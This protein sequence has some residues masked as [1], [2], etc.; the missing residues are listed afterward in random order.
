MQKRSSTSPYLR[1]S[2]RQTAVADSRPVFQ[3]LE[4]RKLLTVLWANPDTDNPWE[5]QMF[6]GW[7]A[8][9]Q[10]LLP[11]D[12]L[13]AGLVEDRSRIV[14]IYVEDASGADVTVEIRDLDGNFLFPWLGQQDDGDDYDPE[15]EVSI[16]TGD[17]LNED[18]GYWGTD[19]D[20]TEGVFGLDAGYTPG[21]RWHAG[22]DEILGTAD[23]GLILDN[24]FHP[25]RELDPGED[26]E[27]GTEDDGEF[28]LGADF[29]RV[30]PET[31]WWHW[32]DDGEYETPDDTR[33]TILGLDPGLW[34][35]DRLLGTADDPDNLYSLDF[36]TLFTSDGAVDGGGPNGL[37]EHMYHHLVDRVAPDGR[38]GPALANDGIADFNN[39][40]GQIIVSGATRFTRIT[41]MTVDPDDLPE[42]IPAIGPNGISFGAFLNQI[43]ILD[44]F[45]EP[46]ET[47]VAVDVDG[48]S[49]VLPPGFG[50]IVVGNPTP[51]D[52]TVDDPGN[53]PL[54]FQPIGWLNYKFESD[55]NFDYR[56]AEGLIFSDS[57]IAGNANFGRLFID[58]A[59][60]GTSRA[61]G[62]FEYLHVGY[63]G[64]A[65]IV[66]GDLDVV[67]VAG[68]AGFIDFDDELTTADGDT[69]GF[70]SVGRSFGQFVVGQRAAIE[71][72]VEGDYVN[73][74]DKPFLRQDGVVNELEVSGPINDFD[75]L[76]ATHTVFATADLGYWLAGEDDE[77]EYISN[78]TIGRAQFI[79]RSTGRTIVQG[80]LGGGADFGPQSDDDTIDWYV[81]AVDGQTALR[82]ELKLRGTDIDFT[83]YLSVRDEKG[84]ILASR[85]ID[86]TTGEV[87]YV[88]EYAGAVYI[89]VEAPGGLGTPTQY[90]LIVEGIEGTS[91]GEFLVLGSMEFSPSP[92]AS[93]T[94]EFGDIGSIRV[95]QDAADEDE[96]T[97]ILNIA[98]T[99]AG[100]IWNVTSG[101]L[102]GGTIDDG[103]VTFG[104][105]T[106]SAGAHIGSILAGFGTSVDDDEGVFTGGSIARVEISAAGSIG[107]VIALAGGGNTEDYGDFGGVGL[108]GTDNITRSAIT[109]GDG[110]GVM[111]AEN[112]IFA[113]GVFSDTGLHVRAGTNGL[114]GQIDLLEAGAGMVA[115]A[116]GEFE[117]EGNRDLSRAVTVDGITG[118]AFNLNAGTQSASNVRFVRAPFV[119]SNGQ[120]GATLELSADGVNSIE[121]VDDSGATYTVTI[122]GATSTATLVTQ[123]VSGSRGVALVR[124]TATLSDGGDLIITNNSGLVEIGDLIVTG[125]VGG[126]GNNII[127]SGSGRTD[128]Y[129]LRAIGFFDEI[130]NSTSGDM[131][132]IDVDR[133]S[134]V[135]VKGNLGRTTV[136]RYAP[137]LI[138]P[139]LGVLT[140]APGD[141]NLAGS[142]LRVDPTAVVVNDDVELIGG[143]YDGF[144]NGLSVREV[145]AAF[146]L[147]SVRVDGALGDLIAHT[148]VEEIRVNAD[149]FTPEGEFHGVVGTVYAGGNLEFIDVGDGMERIQPGPNLN[150]GITSLSVIE[151]IVVSGEGRT[152][153]GFIA[154]LNTAGPDVR[155]GDDFGIELIDASKGATIQSAYITTEFLDEYWQSPENGESGDAQADIDRILVKDGNFIDNLVVFDFLNQIDIKNGYWDTNSLSGNS[156]VN[157]IRADLI[158]STAELTDLVYPI[159]PANIIILS[160][161]LNKIETKGA[162]GDIRDLIIDIQGNLGQMKGFN[163]EG[164]TLEVDEFIEKIQAKGRFARSTINAGVLSKMDVDGDIARTTVTVA[165]PIDQFR[166]KKGAI[167]R[168]D[169]T[170]DG[171]DGALKKLEASDEITGR[172]AVSGPIDRIMSKSS[173][174]VAEIVTFS[175]DGDIKEIRAGRDLLMTLDADGNVDKL[176]AGRNIGDGGRIDIHGDLK[177]VDVKKGIFDANLNVDGS[178]TSKFQAF[179][180]A[181]GSSISALSTIKQIQVMDRDTQAAIDITA[182]SGG[183]EKIDLRGGFADGHTISAFDGGIKMA[184]IM[185]DLDGNV[186]SDEEIT[187]L[188]V[189]SN[190]AQ[191]GDITGSVIGQTIIKQ[192][193]ASGGAIDA[194]I[195][196]LHELSSVNI[197]GSVTD[198]VIGAGALINTVK[199]SGSATDSFFLAGLESLGSDG[200]LGGAGLAADTWSFGTLGLVDI[201]GGITDV[202]FAAGVRADAAGTYATPDGDTDLVPGL[203]VIENVR[204]NG[205]ASGANMVIADTAIASVNINDPDATVTQTILDP[206]PWTLDGTV[207]TS[208]TLPGDFTEADGDIIR[209]VMTG[210]GTGAFTQN[211]SGNITGM[212]FVDTTSSTNV[213]I[214]VVGGS[215]NGRVDLANASIEAFDDASFNRFNIQGN[216][217][218]SDAVDFDGNVS[219]F[220]AL[221]VNTTGTIAI[222]GVLGSMTVSQ[223]LDGDFRFGQV[224][225]F[226][227]SGGDFGGATFRSEH[228]GS[229]AASGSMYNSSVYGRDFINTFS[230]GGDLGRKVGTDAQE[231]YVS[232]AGTLGNLSA[233]NAAFAV[234]SAGDVLDRVTFNGNV[235]DTDLLAGLSLGTD[236]AYGGGGTSADSLTDGVVNNVTIRGNFTRSNIAAGVQRG[237]G[238]YYGDSDDVGSLGVSTIANVSISGTASGSSF[239]SETFAFIASGT[240]QQVRAGNTEF[241]SESGN[242]KRDELDVSP[243]PVELVDISV[244]LDV[245]T[246]FIDMF[247]SQELDE[248]SVLG[249]DPDNPFV[250]SAF[251]IESAT[252]GV[253]PDPVTDYTIE[254]DKALKRVRLR[255]DPDFTNVHPDVYTVTIDGAILRSV[256]GTGLDGDGDGVGGDVLSRNFLLGDA[257]DRIEDGTWD[258][259]EG[260]EVDF[261]SATDGSLLLNGI[262]EE[263]SI[264]ERIGDHPDHDPLYF[265]GKMD[266]DLFTFEFEAGQIIQIAFEEVVG[267]GFIGQ[268]SLK[269]DT[270]LFGWQTIASEGALASGFLIESTGEY[271]LQVTG[272]FGAT[273]DL[274]NGNPFGGPIDISVSDDY[275]DPDGNP[276]PPDS[277]ANDIGQYRINVLVFDDGDT[278]FDRGQETDLISNQPVTFSDSIGLPGFNGAPSEAFLDADVFDISRLRIGPGPDGE[279]FTEDDVI[280][281]LLSAGTT[282]TVTVSLE[283]FGSDLGVYAE[284]GVFNTSDT[285][286]IADALMIAAPG[287]V[288]GTEKNVTFT[289]QIP[290]AGEYAVYIQGSF[291]TNYDLTINVNHFTQGTYEQKA[292]QNILLETAGGLGEW[293]GRFGAEFSEFSLDDLGFQDLENEIL[294]LLIQ[295]IQDDFEAIGITVN[296]A[297]TPAAF[298]NEEF[299]TVFVAGD[300]DLEGELIFPQGNYDFIDPLNQEDQ[301]SAVVYVPRFAGAFVP[302]Q[303]DVLAEALGHAVVHELLH[304]FGLRNTISDPMAP[305]MSDEIF[306]AGSYGVDGFEFSFQDR[307]DALFETLY[308]GVWLMGQQNEVNLLQLMF[309]SV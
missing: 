36:G 84:R 205:V 241:G 111:R 121:L 215:G 191:A 301:Q 176:R 109:A 280:T 242:L 58:G 245:D 45:V 228:L 110:I 104:L 309:E 135:I 112:R 263:I 17:P 21:Y 220:T 134:E 37:G 252:G 80:T 120:E 48:E 94:T 298:G 299:T 95:G 185:G 282:V 257:G 247:F 262:N 136:N 186:F 102:I 154:A 114:G 131:V 41:M 277:I 88:P 259:G 218:G 270:G 221:T 140:A 182:H 227:V 192:L 157:L 12:T 14:L 203:S 90:D 294:T 275:V 60:F 305:S 87:L 133:V 207:F 19:D 211:G 68:D 255:V 179:Q 284:V 260:V 219:T 122:T 141:D 271:V 222:D 158:M 243:V 76:E 272:N 139:R 166:S 239:F 97:S 155:T 73:I 279:F 169:M 224:G 64:G 30:I 194:V 89:V 108:D 20:E 164:L 235:S 81:V 9:P 6:M 248:S 217:D 57:D 103:T 34:S 29:E 113:T 100:S 32:G 107:R 225:S 8:M 91:F 2:R 15:I 74:V 297:L 65:V 7:V 147:E 72:F 115:N 152:L 273:A 307:A 188:D 101:N 187:K 153:S 159:T 132:A 267:S 105:V 149:G 156:D 189:K 209:I 40:I 24:F 161:N 55:S 256:S 293:L 123:P 130:R 226:T 93:I 98:I 253:D 234:V 174:V 238:G 196:A 178:I 206:T 85:G 31:G 199:V 160:G 237:V 129:L 173:D 274:L 18:D 180:V 244:Q 51:Y 83:E 213:D 3:P 296:V 246:F 302:G 300:Y 210:P 79:G 214:T 62:A 96:A 150:A 146:T 69:G 143:P 142:A 193:K 236:G 127:L 99:S 35:D 126:R 38:L 276:I 168:L 278:G 195:L 264:V 16:A 177:Q 198:A 128:V 44:P 70:I 183:I 117:E 10:W 33:A 308:G 265:P 50:H 240:V 59:L 25:V 250:G 201:S 39:G 288:D 23:D 172:I 249:N 212:Q 116:E 232:T 283:E 290:E 295:E 56:P 106:L 233:V 119:Y 216:I 292:E 269:V 268:L 43:T 137:K 306:S 167:T 171:P 144:L 75:D 26:D 52:W 254:Y 124:V 197:G 86:G 304:T 303:S 5:T 181:D 42:V 148:T 251:T 61:P 204:V 190:G 266:T 151:R 78:D 82:V 230:L 49:L 175:G 231:A 92:Q 1:R 229:F 47:G 11:D 165:G 286:G 66:D 125:T 281:S 71:T 261:L 202:V 77:L 118:G 4:P 53:N 67:V 28:D 13:D 291:R 289:F 145:G 170:I 184:K 22:F 163:M 138:G 258:A 27:L 162:K 285:T 208:A 223:V 287:F 46:I 63:L 200:A 54:D